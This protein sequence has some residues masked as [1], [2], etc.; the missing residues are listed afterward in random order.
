MP[1]LG[2]ESWLEATKAVL[3]TRALFLVVAWA[4]AWML[5]VTRGP[6]EMSMVDLW[7][8]WDAGIF[9]QI[10]VFGYTDPATDPHAT[11]FFPLFPGLIAV[12]D[13]G[14]FVSAGG[15]GMLISGAASIVASAYLYRLAELEVGE[16]AGRHAV[17]YLVLFPTAV[18]LVAAYS[19]ALF[20]AGAI[21]AFY[22]A[23]RNQWMYAAIPCAVATATRA[24]G[25][26]LLLGL[27]VELIRQRDSRNLK[28]G[29][30][31]LGAGLIPVFAYGAYLAR[32]KG[33]FFYFFVDQ[34]E[35]WHRGFVGPLE[36]LAN[37]WELTTTPSS[38]TNW[39]LTWRF[40]L[41]AAAVGLIVL[42]VLLIRREWGYAAYTGTTL[43]A[44]MTST[45][46]F[47]IPR[48]LLS[49]FPMYLLMAGF[50]A[51]RPGRHELLVA[52]M[53]PVAALGVIVF[54][55]GAWFY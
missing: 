21:P 52:V 41:V 46:Y 43:A 33:D 2:R 4:G 17:L 54:T 22:Y 11:A 55:Q 6:L 25:I 39:I 3:I 48:M 49:V 28:G 26:F 45:W 40:E 5:A 34:R 29:L 38:P 50:T 15:A 12:V 16:G 31:A 14:P 37:T 51:G 20:L 24:A 36:S 18:F 1:G 23:R 27:A 30:V 53:A 35:G 19:E 47:S 9:I 42:G 32:I 13:L 10:A 7:A 8:R 44:L